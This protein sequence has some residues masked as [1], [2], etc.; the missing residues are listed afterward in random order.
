MRNINIV[1]RAVYAMAPGELLLASRS[2]SMDGEK[3][4]GTL[5]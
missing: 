1:K 3:Y 5:L 4:T 2:F